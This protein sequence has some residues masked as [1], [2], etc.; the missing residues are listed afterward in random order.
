MAVSAMVFDDQKRIL[1]FRHT[2]RKLEWGIPTGGLEY[3]EQPHDAVVREFHEETGLT[4]A[5]RRLLLADSSQYDQHV[6]L[7][8]LCDIVGGE[9]Q[10]SDEVCEMRYYDVNHLPPM[11][12]D[13]KDLIR[14]IHRTLF[15]DSAKV[16]SR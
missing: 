16:Y 10:A 11:L 12:F 13:E 7:V 3:W 9:F 2:Y 5:V 8:Y 15:E 6:S 14:S 4:I 1:L